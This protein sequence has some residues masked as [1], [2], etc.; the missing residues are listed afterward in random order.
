MLIDGSLGRADDDNEASLS[1][2]NENKEVN[3]NRDG[4]R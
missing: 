4:F 1:L 3:N 2:D